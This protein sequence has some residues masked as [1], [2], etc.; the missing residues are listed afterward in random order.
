MYNCTA[1]PFF[2]IYTEIKTIFF[3]ID[4]T[5]IFNAVFIKFLL[6]WKLSSK[7]FNLAQKT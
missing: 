1:I 2:L 7:M 5:T 4:F 6:E 3:A